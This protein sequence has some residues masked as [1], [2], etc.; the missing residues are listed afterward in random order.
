L[1]AKKKNFKICVGRGRN[2]FNDYY[3]LEKATRSTTRSTNAKD[4][5]IACRIHDSSNKKTIP[6]EAQTIATMNHYSIQDSYS[7]IEENLE[8]FL[9]SRGGP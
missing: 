8:G 3:K 4:K 7:R 6:Y 9:N 1:L 2:A 5:R